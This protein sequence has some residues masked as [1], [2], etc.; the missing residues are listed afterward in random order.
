MADDA[1][2]EGDLGPL[3]LAAD[4]PSG[5]PSRVA[6][7]RRLVRENL[8]TVVDNAFPVARAILGA[9]FDAELFD[10]FLADGGPRTSYYRQIPGDLVA[11]ALAREHPY[12]DLLHYEW[13]ELLAARHPADIDAPATDD[14]RVRPNPTLQMGVYGRPVHVMSREQPDP[15]PFA[16]PSAY[17]VWRRPRTD[18]VVFHRVGLVIARAIELASRAAGD[19]APLTAAELAERVAVEAGLAPPVIRAALDAALAELR[20]REGI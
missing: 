5:L 15:A 16:A 10:G 19:G 11:W 12:A 3:L 1:R 8:R 6:V 20:S 2:L 7:Y 13:L 4:A 17:L 14:G 18:E 9:R